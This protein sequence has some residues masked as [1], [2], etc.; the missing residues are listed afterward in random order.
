MRKRAAALSLLFC[1]LL[2]A[3]C[4]RQEEAHSEYLLAMD[5]VM[6][7]T[8]YGESGEA[9]LDAAADIIRDLEGLLSVT[10]EASAVAELNRTGEL[11]P[12]D[13][14]LA[15][16]LD[17]AL[18][19]GE[20]TGGALDITVYPVVKAWGFTGDRYQVPDGEE[21]AELL[22]R[23][24]W[25]AI[26][27]DGQRVELPEG[28]Q[29]DFGALAKGYAG[30]LS[31]QTLREAG[32]TSA[33]LDLGGNIQTV[34]SKLD[35]SPWRIGIRDPRDPESGSYLGELELVD[36]AAVTS[37]GYQRYFEEDGET[38]W[39]IIDPATGY[40]ARSGLI[41]VT[42]VGDDGALCDGLSTALF[43]LGREAALDYWRTWGGFEAVLVEED[44]TVT[45]T[46][47]LADAFTLTGEDYTLSVAE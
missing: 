16:L 2:T 24:D 23:V 33:L 12:V 37:G 19:L 17:L 13:N 31:A 34:G 26:S 44:G 25:S 28:A 38:Y 18:E 29:V 15:A 14:D 46:A 1:L 4:S 36:Q 10:D 41:S 40:P 22:E 42:V 47:G 35:G 5:T 8:A 11:E 9:G 6:T 27:W 21:L 20:R 39:H 3:G 30:A 7:L 45:V 43:V 32:V